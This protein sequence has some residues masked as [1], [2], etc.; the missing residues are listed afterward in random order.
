MK[1]IGYPFCRFIFS[2]LRL[3]TLASGTLFLCVIIAGGERKYRK[4]LNNCKI[5]VL[6]N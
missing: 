6:I 1:Y 5:H 2:L 4:Q 3:P